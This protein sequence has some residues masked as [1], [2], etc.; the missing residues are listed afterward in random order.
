MDPIKSFLSGNLDTAKAGSGALFKEGKTGVK[1]PENQ[2]SGPN[3][4]GILL[5]MIGA[6]IFIFAVSGGMDNTGGGGGSCPTSCGGG[7]SITV[8][9]NCRCPSD[10][11]RIY[12]VISN[13]PS[14]KGYK[15]CIP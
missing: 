14:M 7:R 12:S 6:G 13:P 8:A 2:P 5:A 9:P 1:A 10:C 15:Q 4:W 11:P 3:V